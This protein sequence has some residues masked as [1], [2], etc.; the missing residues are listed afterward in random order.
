MD[1][2]LE[3]KYRA[4]DS[5]RR[6]DAADEY[7]L[8]ETKAK[9]SYSAERALRPHLAKVAGAKILSTTVDNLDVKEDGELSGKITAEVAFIDMG[10]EKKASIPLNINKGQPQVIVA[11][12]QKAFAAAT[13]VKEIVAAATST[14][15]T[16]SLSDFKLIDDGTRYLKVYHTA[17]YGDLEPI[18]AISKE[19][20]VTASDKKA[21]LSEIFQDEATSWPADVN[22]T[23][24]FT[25]PAIEEKVAKEDLQYVVKAYPEAKSEELPEEN[26]YMYKVADADRLSAEAAQKT[27]DA[28][29]DRITQRAVSAFNDAWKSRG[30]GACHIKNT[31]STWDAASGVGDI[32]IEA[33]VLDGKDTKLVPFTVAINGASM[34]LPD[35]ANLAAMLKEA[36]VVAPE[37]IGINLTQNVVLEKKATPMAPTKNNYQDVLRMPK[38]FLPASLKVGDVIECDGLRYRLAS[39]SEGQL[40]NQRD[41]AS[42]WLF[43]RVHGDEKPIYHQESY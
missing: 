14:S 43:E 27:L 21:L 26:N 37:T 25:E 7:R 39:K 31:T 22:F 33:E 41:T 15:V 35:F 16:A 36:K 13:T 8:S 24:E 18:G 38:D 34:K 19:E 42:H 9:L 32:K 2:N 12:L 4:Y 28:L 10:V 29:K 1:D 30:T 3:G 40:S 11:D 5:V 20:Y 23:G 6:K 17:A